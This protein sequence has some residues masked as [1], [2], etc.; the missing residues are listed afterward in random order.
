MLKLNNICSGMDH[1]THKEFVPYRKPETFTFVPVN[2]MPFG[3]MAPCSCVAGM[4]VPQE[5]GASIFTVK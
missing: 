5:Y 4:K 3:H 1:V 2:I